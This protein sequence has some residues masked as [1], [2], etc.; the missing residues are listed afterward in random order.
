M[1][2]SPESVSAAAA[3]AAGKMPAD[4]RVSIA[5]ADGD[6]VY[7]LSSFT[8]LLLYQDPK[9]KAQSKAMVEFVKWA[10]QDGQKFAPDMGYAPLPK[11]VVD[12]ELKSLATIK[13][14]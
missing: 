2:A 5:N 6:A 1:K 3:A 7:P 12:L 14:Q 13:T 9:D 8:W 10:L 4:F 11:A